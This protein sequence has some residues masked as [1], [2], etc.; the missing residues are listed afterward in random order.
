MYSAANMDSAG[1]IPPFAAP[2]GG[3]VDLLIIAGEHS[4]DQHAA[5][6]VGELQSLRPGLKVAAIGGPAL[7]QAG[8]QL[9]FDLTE[10]SVVG[11]V[12]VLRHMGQFK[13]LLRH[14]EN[15][16]ATH[17]PRS[18]LF[19][20]YPG[21]NLRLADRLFK[22]S[23]S[24]KSGGNIGLYYYISP[25]IWAWKAGRRFKM[26][27]LLDGMGVIFPFE[28]KSYADT[29]LPVRFVGHPFVSEGLPSNLSL[30]PS[31]PILLLPGSRAQAVARIF[32][33][34]LDAFS[35]MLEQL[36]GERALALY[37]DPRIRALL[38][39]ILSG[40]P[41]LK[42]RVELRPAGEGAKAKACLISSGTM[43]LNCAL[44]GLPGAICYRAHPLTYLMGR[45]FIKVPH[46]GIA[47]LLLP[48]APPYREYIQGE[49]RPEAIAADLVEAIDKPERTAASKVA[50]E[51]LRTVLGGN[52]DT[53]SPAR[54]LID[55]AKL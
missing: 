37:P 49:A 30:D 53:P 21:F 8:A 42:D 52:S 2:D 27:R 11:F 32:P 7:R 6:L 41:E 4:G 16:I 51:Q 14:S 20:D 35:V 55:S 33:A 38:E 23:L 26:A 31:G 40:R 3:A 28:L 22:A 12:E 25:Q 24:R 54:W 48:D 5:K 36:P 9:L 46:L 44:A 29:T 39:D 18:V 13:S 43:S 15:W 50:A 45:M 1:T 17:K 47:N 10:F 19:V 34:M